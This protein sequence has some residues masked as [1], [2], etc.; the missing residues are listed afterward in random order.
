MRDGAT[1]ST[2]IYFPRRGCSGSALLIRTP[3]GK[4]RMYSLPVALARNGY[5]VL[6]QDV[7]GRF[8]SGGD[9]E[10]AIREGSDGVDTVEWIRNQ[11]WFD[12]GLGLIGPSY[13]G[14]AGLAAAVVKRKLF[15]A[16]VLIAAPYDWY[17]VVYPSGVFQLHWAYPWA[18]QMSGKS[19]SLSVL[20]KW[21][22]EIP[23]SLMLDTWLE[24]REY[25]NYWQS[26]AI[27]FSD[28]LPSFPILHIGGWYDF[29]LH[30]V[31]RGWELLGER[32]NNRLVIGPWSHHTV[33]N[34]STRL[35][36]VDFGPHSE[37][38]LA[39]LA[40]K[41]FSAC[42]SNS[43]HEAF[44]S[45]VQLFV[46]GR[47][48]W[49]YCSYWNAYGKQ[50]TFHTERAGLGKEIPRAHSQRLFYSPSDPAP[51]LGGNCW[52]LP[53]IPGLNPGPA[54]QNSL[55]KRN[56]VACYFSRQ[57]HEQ[58]TCLGPVAF[59]L[60]ADSS[61]PMPIILKLVELGQDGL[62]RLIATSEPAVL[63]EGRQS[64][65]AE[66]KLVA[67]EF[68]AGNKIGIIIQCGSFPRYERILHECEVVIHHGIEGSCLH[69]T[70]CDGD[71]PSFQRQFME[72]KDDASY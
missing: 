9:Y 21:P 69:L 6:M 35:L 72:V 17:N 71:T 19:A 51:T 36:D 41:W 25:D 60:V 61:G 45:K 4:R 26:R 16:M 7:R 14:W 47:C 67:H 23:A 59:R 18:H 54:P 5:I 58:V 2:D 46:T 31:L 66:I 64:I 38:K 39:E 20:N 44:P 70:L 27:R 43:I 11:S 15:D 30:E 29:L 40:H 63:A 10:F 52:P 22:E 57:L 28:G 68:A 37:L 42:F 49:K 1:L 32:A 50:V 56:D 3:Y 8:S 24:H 33:L 13:C 48:E 55:V 62:I 12:G 65:S 53:A 34:P